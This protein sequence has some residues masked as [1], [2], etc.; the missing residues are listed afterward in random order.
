MSTKNLT[1]FFL[2]HFDAK[3]PNSIGGKPIKPISGNSLC[4]LSSLLSLKPKIK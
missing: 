4:F 2:N 3:K 1:L